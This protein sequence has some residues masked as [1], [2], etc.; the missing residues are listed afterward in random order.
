MNRRFKID[1]FSQLATLI[2][3]VISCHVMLW[4]ILIRLL[5]DL[6]QECECPTPFGMRDS[7]GRDR[8]LR[9]F[10]AGTTCT[11]VS[12]FGSLAGLLG[13][14]SLPLAVWVAQIKVALPE[15]YLTLL[16]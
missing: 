1:S 11:D 13:A 12:A 9:V 16:T 4:K 3:V 5:T 15:P 2:Q 10:G 7:E 14:S 6:A 8:T